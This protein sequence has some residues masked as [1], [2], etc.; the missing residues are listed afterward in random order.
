MCEHCQSPLCQSEPNK[1]ETPSQTKQSCKRCKALL[2]ACEYILNCLNVGG[3]QSRQFAEEIAYLKK[4]IRENRTTN[5][6]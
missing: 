6:S 4:V 3:E 5:K 1:T 2:Q